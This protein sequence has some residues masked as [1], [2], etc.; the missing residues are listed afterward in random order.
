MHAQALLAETWRQLRRER[1]AWVA[2][3]LGVAGNLLL[4]LWLRQAARPDLWREPLQRWWES[5]Q[6]PVA[7]LLFWGGGALLLFLLGWLLSLQAEGTLIA[8][9]RGRK[10]PWRK[11]RRWLLRLIGIDTLVFLPL[12]LASIAALILIAGLLSGSTLVALRSPEPRAMLLGG[13][14][15]TLLCLIPLLL[16]LLPVALLTLVVRRLAF[17]ATTQE[18]LGPRQALGRAWSVVRSAPGATA[19]SALLLWGIA[20]TASTALSAI[21]L[22]LHVAATVPHLATSRFAGWTAPL[23]VALALLE[24]APRAALFAFAGL[25]WTHAYRRLRAEAREQ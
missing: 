24:W 21:F 2:G 17:R 13:W 12:L 14:G 15:L 4:G 8:V 22:L 10:R 25:G 7:P 1:P 6:I 16:L 18:E 20:Y 19:I 5:Q 3:L 23:Q 11:G 9:A